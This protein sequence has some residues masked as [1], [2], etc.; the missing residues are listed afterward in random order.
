MVLRYVTP[1]GVRVM[2][3]PYTDEEEQELYRRF[4]GGGRP[5][6]V[7]RTAKTPQ[8]AGSEAAATNRQTQAVTTPAA[9]AADPQP[10]PQPE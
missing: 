8:S 3:P 4:D 10:D 5:W 9:T 6:K 1:N 7:M 2:G